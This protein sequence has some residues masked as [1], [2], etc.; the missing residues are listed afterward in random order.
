[1]TTQSESGKP[2]R[3]AKL[4]QIASVVAIFIFADVLYILP[5][6]SFPKQH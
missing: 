2:L 1:M 5:S 6:L 4:F 3:I